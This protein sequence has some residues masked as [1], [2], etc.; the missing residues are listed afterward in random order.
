MDTEFLI[1]EFPTAC[2]VQATKAANLG[3][4]VHASKT[5]HGMLHHN[6]RNVAYYPMG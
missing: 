3:C 4:A 6:A 2:Y 1:L 5:C